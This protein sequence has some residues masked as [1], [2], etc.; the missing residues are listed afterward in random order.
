MRLTRPYLLVDL[1]NSREAPAGRVVKLVLGRRREIH[2]RNQNALCHRFLPPVGGIIAETL[3]RIN[4]G[5]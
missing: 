2:C 1:V 3:Q 5:F 4:A